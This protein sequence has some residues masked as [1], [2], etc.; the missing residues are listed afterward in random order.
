MGH[1]DIATLIWERQS[2]SLRRQVEQVA[3][4]MTTGRMLGDLRG[5]ALAQRDDQ[6]IVLRF[7]NLR[8]L[9]SELLARRRI[10]PTAKQ[11]VLDAL[12]EALRRHASR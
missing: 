1:R 8:Q 11:A 7:H 2:I 10:Q 12:V 5:T 3:D 4:V 6:Q 9:A